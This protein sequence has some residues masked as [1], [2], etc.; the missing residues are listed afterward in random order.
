MPLGLH[1]GIMTLVD[2]LGYR[3]SAQSIL[4]IAGSETLVYGSMNAGVE[5][6]AGE[7]HPR[8]VTSLDELARRLNLAYHKVKE[9]DGTVKSIC[10]PTDIE[11]HCAKR[12]GKYYIIDTARLF[13][14]CY[15]QTSKR[16]IFYRLFRREFLTLYGKPLS[17]DSLSQVCLFV[18]GSVYF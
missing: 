8:L 6:L 13:P 7:K 17:S 1:A 10:L 12:S 15:P 9:L 2:F 18:L 16:E 11:V 14:P 4:P 5:I 3:L